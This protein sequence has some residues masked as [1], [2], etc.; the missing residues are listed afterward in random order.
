MIPNK[1]ENPDGLH[2]KYHIAKVSG[3]PMDEDS[4][5]FVLRLDKGGDPLHVNACRCAI[6]IYASV[7]EKKHPELAKDLR[8]RYGQR[9]SSI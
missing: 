1:E 7:I 9:V 5:Y 6:N 2:A 8:T 4:E 3:E